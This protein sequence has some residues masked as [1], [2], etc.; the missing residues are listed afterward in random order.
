MTHIYSC[1]FRLLTC[2][3]GGERHCERKALKKINAK[4]FPGAFYLAF[5]LDVTVLVWSNQYLPLAAC[6]PSLALI[7]L[8]ETGG[9]SGMEPRE[10]GVKWNIN[11]FF[12]SQWSN[13]LMFLLSLFLQWATFSQSMTYRLRLIIKNDSGKKLYLEWYSCHGQKSYLCV[14]FSSYNIFPGSWQNSPALPP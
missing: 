3:I 13:P 11:W 4:N 8:H 5:C 14:T 7:S 6:P 2:Q 9:S 1:F 12:W 10:T